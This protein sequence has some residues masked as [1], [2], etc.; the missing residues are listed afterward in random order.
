[1]RQADR[2]LIVRTEITASVATTIVMIR[3]DVAGI[4]KFK[5]ENRLTSF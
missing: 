5:S 3:F 1:M 4:V 2:V